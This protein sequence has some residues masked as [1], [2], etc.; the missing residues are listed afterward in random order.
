MIWERV[1]E[2]N[3]CCFS[4][5]CRFSLYFFNVI[6]C[7]FNGWS[8]PKNV[9]QPITCL[10]QRET[11][12]FVSPWCD[13]GAVFKHCSPNYKFNWRG[14]SLMKIYFRIVKG[15]VKAIF[16]MSAGYNCLLFIR[17]FS[18]ELWNP[19]IWLVHQPRS[20]F[21]G[22]NCGRG[23]E[24]LGGAQDRGH[25]FSRYRPPGYCRH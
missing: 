11:D 17:G 24:A 14:N 9:W 15:N 8:H 13:W 18:N 1:S 10:F 22:I 25:S 16:F 5:C 19:A 20:V 3:G 12:R 2:S 7:L 23:R 4:H 6:A 21:I